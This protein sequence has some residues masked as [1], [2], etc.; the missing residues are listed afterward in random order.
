MAIAAR[1]AP[2]TGDVTFLGHQYP[3]KV[4]QNGVF[5]HIKPAKLTTQNVS[6]SPTLMCQNT[7]KQL[8][9]PTLMGSK[10]AVII[11]DVRGVTTPTHSAQKGPNPTRTGQKWP[12]GVNS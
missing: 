1:M 11:V 12:K 4:G 8:N 5:R 6:I 10:W 7:L 3:I 9:S 2:P